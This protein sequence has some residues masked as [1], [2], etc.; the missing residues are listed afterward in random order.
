V[1]GRIA[2]RSGFVKYG[3]RDI[4]PLAG[5]L[6]LEERRARIDLTQAQL[7]GISMPLT[8]EVTPGS[9]SLT[10]RL[11]A[12]KQQLEKTVRCLSNEGVQI[13]GDFD[14]DADVGTRGKGIDLA[15]NLGGT[16]TAEV[17][18]G[19]VKKFALLGNIL[20]MKDITA[21]LKE[22]G[23]K[24]DEQGFP[25][26]TISLKGHFQEGR[27]IVDESGFRSDA[28]GLAAS[29]WISILD[30]QSRLAVLVAPL[31][32]LDQ[33]VRKVPILGYVIG[34][35]LTSVPVGVSGDIRDPLVLP[36]GPA[37]VTSE[38]MGIFTRTLKLPENI[39]APLREKPAGDSPSGN[40]RP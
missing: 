16:V 19:T 38:L 36:L 40:E 13:T 37:A 25:Y 18:D 35:T 2:L 4:T 24:L 12:R 23:P 29:G 6:V 33:I 26:R 20:S 1:T 34:G 3:T 30:F 7:C 17:R 10:A 39:L 31:G 21:L 22:G 32:R 28:L 9:M 14:L 8:L 15:R 5:T 11:H 27:F